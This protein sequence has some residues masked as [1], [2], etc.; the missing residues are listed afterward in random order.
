MIDLH[1]AT[2]GYAY[3]LPQRSRAVAMVACSFHVRDPRQHVHVKATLEPGRECVE[4]NLR[5]S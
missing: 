4:R 2:L 3:P 1:A 5:T